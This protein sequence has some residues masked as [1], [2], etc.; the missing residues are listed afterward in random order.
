MAAGAAVARSIRVFRDATLSP[1]ALSKTLAGVARRVR[2][3]AIASGDAKGNYLTLVDGRRGA[4]EETVRPDG[5]IIYRFAVLGQAAAFALSYCIARSPRKDGDYVRAW[6]VAVNGRRWPG[7]LNDL[8]SGSE[9]MI[10]NPMPYARTIDV[11]HTRVHAPPFIVEGARQAAQKAFP[12]LRFSRSLIV[13]PAG[14]APN[15]IVTP[16]ILKGR[17]RRGRR[18]AARVALRAD[19]RPG[20]QMTYPALIITE[21]T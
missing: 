11:G 15:G 1:A 12:S 19:T 21:K 18:H 6:F 5:Q 4:M 16:Y 13:I 9:V 17:F 7:D 8:P 10:T 14:N 2:D 20:A 3:D